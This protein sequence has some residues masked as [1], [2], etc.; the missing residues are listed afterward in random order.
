MVDIRGGIENVISETGK[1]VDL[2]LY[3]DYKSKE[4]FTSEK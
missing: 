3:Y 1:N 4:V 2:N